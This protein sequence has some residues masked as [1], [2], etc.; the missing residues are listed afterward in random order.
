MKSFG[1]KLL[2]STFGLLAG[3]SSLFAQHVILPDFYA[4]PSARVFGDTLYVYPSRDPEG[5][6]S[7]HEMVDWH[8]FST[9]D[10][11][12]W[13]DHGV[14]FDLD[15]ISWADEDAWAPDCIERNGK[16]Y[17]YFTAG[18]QIGVAVADSP[19]GPFKDA[20]G[21]PLVKRDELG[22]HWMLD[23]CV[24][25]DDDGQA[26]LYVGGARK[27]AVV[28]L[29]EDMVTRDGPLIS[30]EMEGYFEGI[31]MHKRNG[32]Y[33]ASYPTRPK[34]EDASKMVY[35]IADNPMG[36]FEFKGQII[37]NHSLN[38]HG[39]IT[40]FKDQWY[41]FYH[42]AGPSSW[43]R[44]VCVAPLSYNADGTIQPIELPPVQ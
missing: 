28:K 39:S 5:A 6:E 8:V 44:R 35:S 37:D 33:Y 17:Y 26:Y 14:I 42:V 30:L 15:D 20:L 2:W 40:E 12:T 4:D 41:L 29:K 9:K 18:A 7:F 31:W 25:I 16:Y 23:P 11:K 27:L 21:K 3:V 13:T 36:P 43:E 32:I 38:V 19:T 22:I 1:V 24:F 34:G 10:L